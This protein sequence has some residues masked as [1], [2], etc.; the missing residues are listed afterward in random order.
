MPS[1]RQRTT[2]RK[3]NLRNGALLA[4]SE[5]AK[6]VN[7]P[8]AHDVARHIQQIAIVL[9]PSV[10]QA[11]KTNDSSAQKLAKHVEGLLGTLNVAIQHLNN[12]GAGSH[13][14][15]LTE[16][17]QFQT[18]LSK[19][20]TELQEIQSSQYTTKL[21]SQ[22]E[23]RERILGLKE[24]LSQN[25]VDLMVRLLVTVLD[26]SAQHQ[27]VVMCRL[28]TTTR[29]H[30]ALLQE[31]NALVRRHVSLARKHSTLV[32]ISQRR[33]RTS[34]TRFRRLKGTCNEI[35]LFR[36]TDGR[37]ACSVVLMGLPFFFYTGN[38]HYRA[39]L[40]PLAQLQSRMVFLRPS[41]TRM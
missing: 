20:H 4:V 27:L 9:K 1:T 8:L 33:Q 14:N 17:Y 25:I 3:R 30:G 19:I 39:Q 23:I 21:A 5:A 12:S 32:H 36:Q 15:M 2:F 40:N 11:P 29:E 38:F 35:L 6:L 16:I 13:E 34:D 18:H 24:E 10:L 28:N 22:T 41:M 26:F 7:I 31:H 37:T